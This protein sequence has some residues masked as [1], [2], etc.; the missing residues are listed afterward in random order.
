MPGIE[1]PNKVRAAQE[2]KALKKLMILIQTARRAPSVL[3]DDQVPPLN[4]FPPSPS[5]S[6]IP[7]SDSP[8]PPFLSES[9]PPIAASTPPPPPIETSED[10]FSFPPP[11]PLTPPP[12]TDLP[13]P[14]PPLSPSPVLPPGSPSISFDD[15][16]ASPYLSGEPES[17]EIRASD[18]YV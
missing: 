15:S 2:E 7:S 9:P 16:M 18:A 1:T 14:P 3:L 17:N 4:L 11:P 12:S 6:G 5:P 13:L 10:S 8:H